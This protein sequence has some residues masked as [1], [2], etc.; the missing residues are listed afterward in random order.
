MCIAAEWVKQ[1]RGRRV[2]EAESGE[3]EWG[4]QIEE[5]WLLQVRE[6]AVVAKGFNNLCRY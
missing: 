6:R 5:S 4:K 3:A 1:S 2:G